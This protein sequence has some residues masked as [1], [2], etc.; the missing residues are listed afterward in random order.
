MPRIQSAV[1]DNY[2]YGAPAVEA[3]V[4]KFKVKKAGRLIVTFLNADGAADIVNTLQVSPDGSTWADTSAANN[5]AAVADETVVKRGSASFET[6]LRAGEDLYLRL[7]AVGGA[8]GQM[9]VRGEAE[10]DILSI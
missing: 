9:Q 7:L 1:V 6:L 10:L 3:E 4:L 5:L 2:D 8:R